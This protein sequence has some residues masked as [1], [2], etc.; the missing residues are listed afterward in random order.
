MAKDPLAHNLGVSL[1]QILP[2]VY[3]TVAT[4]FLGSLS[5]GRGWWEGI[6][7]PL[8]VATRL[9]GLNFVSS[10]NSWD[11]VYL[12]PTQE[13]VISSLFGR[14]PIQFLPGFSARDLRGLTQIVT[15]GR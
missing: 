9:H 6:R 8:L 5:R 1:V 4:R 7:Q 10:G 13:L 15:V 2:L 14:N 3:V 12:P 11:R